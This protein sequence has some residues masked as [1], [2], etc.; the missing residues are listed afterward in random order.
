MK[1]CE[2]RETYC[3]HRFGRACY[4]SC[5]EFE[6]DGWFIGVVHGV[7]KRF[8]KTKV[9]KRVKSNLELLVQLQK[10]KE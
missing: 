10:I 6:S 9:G 3:Y 4:S 8:L 1:G 7:Y 2:G 5:E